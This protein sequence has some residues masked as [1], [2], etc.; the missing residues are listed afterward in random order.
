MK[1]GGYDG[2]VREYRSP[3]RNQ[4]SMKRSKLQMKNVH[5]HAAL[6]LRRPRIT[7]F[8]TKVLLSSFSVRKVVRWLKAE[9]LNYE[10]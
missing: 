3:I 4:H 6:N 5:F 8:G 7:L 9:D 1:V 2:K 10:L